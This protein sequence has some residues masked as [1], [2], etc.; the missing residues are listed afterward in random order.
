MDVA[1]V[2]HVKDKAVGG[3]VKYPVDCHCQFHRSQIG[4]QMTAGFRDMLNQEFP[5]FTAQNRQL[6]R[7]RALTSAGE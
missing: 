7:S 1:L 4:G 6:D 2:A 5:Q 3:G